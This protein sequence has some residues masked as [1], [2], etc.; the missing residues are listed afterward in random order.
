MLQKD[1]GDVVQKV[2]SLRDAAL[3]ADEYTGGIISNIAL[4]VNEAEVRDLPTFS[5][6]PRPHSAHLHA[7]VRRYQ[8][9]FPA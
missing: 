4:S 3:L 2:T 9:T 8:G 6:I 7:M 5:A 1:R